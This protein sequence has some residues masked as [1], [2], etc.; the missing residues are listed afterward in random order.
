MDLERSMQ[1]VLDNHVDV[2]AAQKFLA[3]PA[4]VQEDIRRCGMLYN[5][6]RLDR[7]PSAMLCK[8]IKSRIAC[9]VAVPETIRELAQNLV[10]TR[11]FPSN[12]FENRKRVQELCVN[13]SRIN[14]AKKA[15]HDENNSMCFQTSESKTSQHRVTAL[16]RGDIHC[17]D[18]QPKDALQRLQVF[19]DNMQSIKNHLLEP[20]EATGYK[21]LLVVDV[22]TDGEEWLQRI[23]QIILDK[24]SEYLAAR[25]HVRVTPLHVGVTHLNSVLKSCDFVNDCIFQK[26]QSDVFAGIYILRADVRLLQQCPHSWRKDQLTFFWKTALW[27][28]ATGTMVNDSVIYVPKHVFPKFQDAL[29]NA[30]LLDG[31][32]YSVNDL[33]WLAQHQSLR[34]FA[35]VH[36]D[37]V[38]ASNTAEEQN[39]FYVMTW[40]RLG[41]SNPGKWYQW[42]LR[43]WAQ[44]PAKLT[45]EEREK[46]WRSRV[47][48][49]VDEVGEFKLNEFETLWSEAYPTDVIEWFQPLDSL[50][51]SLTQVRCI[52]YDDDTGF[53]RRVRL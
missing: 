32:P 43:Q 30:A 48:E 51:Q 25:V 5:P 18:L 23:R 26:N 17:K 15:R 20:L 27:N 45:K 40:R 53:V 52:T 50:V 7:N 9:D 22:H 41:K 35:G 24:F 10:S 33:H 34:E 3:L 19:G 8:R 21:V 28:N 44:T 13:E 1:W 14:V 2:D 46:T 16:V 29:S 36:F 38:H 39:P 4:S 11:Q 49:I 12:H 42:K 31:R 6:D 47:Y 37:M